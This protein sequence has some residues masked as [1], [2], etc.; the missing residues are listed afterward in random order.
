[1]KTLYLVRHAK[2]SWS[3]PELIDFERPLNKRGQRDAP[4]MGKVLRKMNVK[5]D[6]IISSPA[7]RA[8]R[9]ARVISSQLGYTVEDLFTAEAIYEATAGELIKLIQGVDNKFN[10][11]MIF[12]HNP[13]LTLVNNYL[14]DKTMENIPTCAIVCLQFDTESWKEVKPDSGKF[15]FFEYPRKYFPKSN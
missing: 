8:F 10:S 7:M 6:L 4:F 9:T 14:S 2:S 15:I 1:M 5:P 13:S 11:L 12:G 3:H